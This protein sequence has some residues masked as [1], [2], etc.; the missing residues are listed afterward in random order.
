MSSPVPVQFLLSASKP[1]LQ[2]YRLSRLNHAAEME[3]RLRTF[4][5]EI[6]EEWAGVIVAQLMLDS[7]GL[8]SIRGDPLQE[9][10]EFP[11]VGVVD[12]SAVFGAPQRRERNFAAD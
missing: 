10:F 5:R 2:E 6:A 4:I 8:G 11:N 12:G 9:A 1:S 7:E 3:K